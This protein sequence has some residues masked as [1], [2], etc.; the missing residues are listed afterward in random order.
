MA[1]ENGMLTSLTG[2]H[3]LITYACTAACDHCF[4]W[5]A[6]GRRRMEVAAMDPFLEQI[7]ALGTVTGVCAEGGEAFLH[8]E[9][10]LHLTR[11]ATAR[12]LSAS[13]LTN[14][15]WATS[16]E[17]ARG[18]SCRTEGGRLEHSWHQHRRMASQGRA[19]R[20]CRHAA[21]SLRRGQPHRQQDGD[22]SDWRDVPRPRGGEAGAARA[23][24]AAGG[25]HEL[26]ARRPRR[27][28]P[29]AL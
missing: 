29:P 22:L 2:I 19:G 15:F 18:P 28:S 25:I 7:A 8:Y 3:F 4:L 24:T 13:A 6:P 21:G 5:G 20:A 10:V 1:E 27:A 11:A 23:G 17:V 9:A 16:R 12:G 26:P 14:A